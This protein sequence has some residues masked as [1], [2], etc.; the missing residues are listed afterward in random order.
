LVIIEKIQSVHTPRRGIDQLFGSSARVDVIW[1]FLQCSDGRSQT[2]LTQADLVRLTDQHLQSVQNALSVLCSEEIGLIG[3][4]KA[5]FC[6]DSE[7]EPELTYKGRKKY[8][9]NQDH[10][11]L[12]ALRLLFENAIGAVRVIREEIGKL[13]GI[14]IAFVHGSFASS[15]QT[16][17]SDVDLVIVG[18]QTLKTISTVISNIEARINRQIDVYTITPSD[19]K[20]KYKSG[21]NFIKSLVQKPKIFIIGDDEALVKITG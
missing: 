14:E 15:T 6:L 5:E 19:W 16:P 20:S 4:V 8:F 21:N 11:W 12:P 9:L 2:L 17:S 10:P 3:F 7:I 13:D 1:A 18:T